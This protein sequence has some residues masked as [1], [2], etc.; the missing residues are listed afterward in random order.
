M[1]LNGTAHHHSEA[2]VDRLVAAGLVQEADRDDHAAVEKAL[3]GLLNR[4][5]ALPPGPPLANMFITR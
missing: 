3:D 5:T 4:F 2:I 1:S